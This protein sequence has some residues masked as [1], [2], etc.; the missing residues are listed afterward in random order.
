[1]LKVFHSGPARYSTADQK[2][3]LEIQETLN[4]PTHDRMNEETLIDPVAE[5][6]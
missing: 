1:M 3:L 4:D 2:E 6:N 5:T